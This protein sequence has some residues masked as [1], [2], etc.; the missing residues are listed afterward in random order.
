M[1]RSDAPRHLPLLAAVAAA[2][3]LGGVLL[4][5]NGLRT[6]T[7]ATVTGCDSSS[8][9]RCP[10]E[11]G[12]D[13]RAF[14]RNGAPF[15]WLADTAWSLFVNLNRSET[16][17]YLDA[18]AAQGFTVVQAAAVF[19]LAGG[20][21]PNQY[22]DA[23]FSSGLAEPSVTPG[24]L[25]DD[26]EQYDYWDH[27]DFVLDQAAQRG[28]VV[29]IAP[30]WAAGQVGDLLTA[31]NA[32]G[33][34][35]FLGKR[36]AAGANVVWM[37]GGDAP[38]E[39]AQDVWRGLAAGLRDGGGQQLIG[40][41]PGAGQTSAGMFGA[42]DPTDFD[43]LQGGQCRNYDERAT[44][45]ATTYDAGRPFV[46]A[47]PIY[48]GHPY[49]DGADGVA[50]ALD[51][52]REAYLSVLAGAAGHTYGNSTVW[53]FRAGDD[54]G[55]G[56]SGA[57]QAPGAG[58]MREIAALLA[59]RPAVGPDGSDRALAANRSTV[60]AYSAAGKAVEVNLAALSGRT[61]QPWWFDPRT[62]AATKL[63]ARPR[64]GTS[65]FTPPAGEGD[66]QDQVLVIDD[67]AAGYGAPGAVPDSNSGTPPS[68]AATS[69]PT[70]A[71]T[72]VPAPSPAPAPKA[73][74]APTPA[75]LPAPKPAPAPAPA[76]APKP[77]PPAPAPKPPAPAP[78]ATDGVWDRLAQCESTGNW[79]I[80]TG[81]GY[82]GGLQFDMGT[83]RAYGGTAYAPSAHQATR[84]QQIA[85]ATKVRDDR[86]GYGA[87][88]AC[89][90]RLGLPR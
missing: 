20:P 7:A 82:F 22:G 14:T 67:A 51:V 79:A 43:L 17:Q 19:P 76:P 11:L 24:N 90:A 75:P 12:V 41:Y 62:G 10:G 9:A 70:H 71:P 64:S 25:S 45:L 34:G 66:S 87:W 40:Y 73:E 13:G 44:L 83:W 47:G 39:G 23:P 56:W 28:M 86:G 58:Q 74:A 81:N 68:G 55:A 26:E 16:E 77:A 42:D 78:P 36:Y 72:P 69:A 38:A 27:V 35:E 48:E 29:A 37:L 57:L 3:V 49:C 88:P 54:P 5:A 89:A 84:E 65:S 50:T 53:P 33:F 8:Q 32:K 46:D 30:V 15:F 1:S 61:V 31:G 21:G 60:L 52:R 80:N 63:D 18:R 85:V 4:A 59:S 6:G 2:V